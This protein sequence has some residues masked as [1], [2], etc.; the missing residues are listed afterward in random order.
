MKYRK[1][2]VLCLLLCP[3]LL[4]A[5][6]GGRRGGGGSGG[7]GGAIN[8]PPM[9]VVVSVHGT[10]KQLDKKII[11]LEADDTRVYMIRRSKKTAFAAS[12]KKIEAKDIDIESRLTVEMMEDHD[13][14]LTA[15]TV[16][17]DPNQPLRAPKTR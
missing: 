15:I 7:G 5:Q 2:A 9:P 17:L 3:C 12:D 6:H 10:L 1:F 14:K 16:R 4:P 11:M 8:A 13:L